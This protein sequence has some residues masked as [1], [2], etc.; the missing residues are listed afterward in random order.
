ML[1][2]SLK[3]P[4]AAPPYTEGTVVGFEVVDGR[5]IRVNSKQ[6]A[7]DL[8]IALQTIADNWNAN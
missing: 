6:E 8:I 4:L 5:F 3:I 2:T 7:L 1:G